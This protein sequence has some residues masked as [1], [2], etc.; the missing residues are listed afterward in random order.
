MKAEIN[1]I[2]W[3]QKAGLVLLNGGLFMV[4]L[5]LSHYV[6]KGEFHDWYVLI[7]QGLF[8]GVF[9]AFGFPYVFGKIANSLGVRLGK[10]IH[11]AL[12]TSEEIETEGPANL[13]RGAE[14]V[15]GKLF[16]TNER[17]IFKSHKINIRTG[18][19]NFPYETIT[20]V[21][22]RKTGK[23]IDNGLRILTTDGSEFDFV[24]A[25]RA[26]WME[27]LQEKINRAN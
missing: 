15:G 17:L 14:A 27:K 4:L 26:S 23:L 12:N 25:E 8:F 5:V 16:L 22:A 18:Q 13:F 1:P 21:Q 20:D 2:N 24:V 3:R 9:M 7:F 11:P 6:W 19:S 10:S